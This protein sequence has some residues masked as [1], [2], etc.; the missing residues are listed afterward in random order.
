MKVKLLSLICS[1]GPLLIMNKLM[2]RDFIGI[3]FDMVQAEYSDMT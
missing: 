2:V 1:Q 3:Q